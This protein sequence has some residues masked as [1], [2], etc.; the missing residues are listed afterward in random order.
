MAQKS[1][2]DESAGTT[3]VPS[4]T[5]IEPVYPDADA[6]DSRWVTCEVVWDPEHEV[7]VN[8]EAD[9]DWE[10]DDDLVADSEYI[11][12]GE[13]CPNIQEAMERALEGSEWE[14][15]TLPSLVIDPDED[16]S[17][18]WGSNVNELLE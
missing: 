4:I 3:E 9:P 1:T 14:S 11:V 5:V 15:F 6:S 8:R 18:E 2:S 13:K 12:D 10:L 7:F 17:P 16:E